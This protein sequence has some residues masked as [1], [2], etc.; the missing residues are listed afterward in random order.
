MKRSLTQDVDF[1]S[2]H[3]PK[4][5][6]RMGVDFEVMEANTKGQV[7]IRFNRKYKDWVSVD[8]LKKVSE[9]A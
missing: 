9:V 4:E 5:V 2:P 7:L 1:N 6:T 3:L 8:L